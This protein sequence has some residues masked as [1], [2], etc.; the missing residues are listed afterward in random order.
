MLNN[1]LKILALFFGISLPLDTK[2]ANLFLL[3]FCVVSLIII[4]KDRKSIS[5]SRFLILSTVILF[6]LTLV[7]FP[8]SIDY[9]NSFKHL[10]RRLTF[11]FVPLIFLFLSYKHILSTKKI[12]FMG[13]IIGCLISGTFLLGSI[14]FKFL[15]ENDGLFNSNLFNYH[16]TYH[17]FTKPLEIHPTYLGSYFFLSLLILFNF[18]KTNFQKKNII[19][20]GL[21]IFYF[22]IIAIFIN[23]RIILGL[24]IL[25]T[26]VYS[27]FLIKH[28]YKTSKVFLLGFLAVSIIGITT[29]F[30]FIKHTYI[31]YRFTNELVWEASAK[32]D[33]KINEDN[34]GDSRLARWESILNVIKE[35]P[36]FGHGAGNEKLLLNTQ[37]LKDKLFFSAN[38]NYDSHNNYLSYGVQFGY[39]GMLMLALFLMSNLYISLAKKDII[40]FIFVIGLTSI[41]L[42]E[43]YLNNNAGIIFIGFYQSLLLFLNIKKDESKIK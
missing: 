14:I 1:T 42:F 25:V 19:I 39:F 18:L 28:L 21:L 6:L 38:S 9:A 17:N 41:C 7:S 16:Y 27:Y 36:I 35:K 13:L 40:Y 22:M 23:S 32:K 2:I 33:S 3:L 29:S 15:S 10:S 11:L 43:N 24:I 4:L 20:G 12:A 31:Y 37:F 5:D 26:I 30:S 34:G 8:F